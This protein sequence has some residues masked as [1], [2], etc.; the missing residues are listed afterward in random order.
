MFD[1]SQFFGRAVLGYLQLFRP[2][3]GKGLHELTSRHFCKK[4]TI[5]KIELPEKYF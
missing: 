5:N 2:R 4:M 1:Q 3:G